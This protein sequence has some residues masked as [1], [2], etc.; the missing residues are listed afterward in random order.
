MNG[1][2]VVVVE[3]VRTPIGRGHAEKG[4]LKDVHPNALLG[5][6]LTEVVARAGIDAAEVDDVIAGCVQQYGEQSLNIARNAWLQAGLPYETPATTIDRQCG[7]AQQAVNFGA[8]QIASGVHD[9]VIGCG[10]EHMGRIPLFVGRQL[11]ATVG[12]PLTPEL[13]E[14]YDLVDQGFSAELIAEQ[15]NLPRG[16]LDEI[17]ARSQQ[18]AE[19]AVEEGRFDREIQPVR[20]NGHVVSTDQG[21]RPGTIVVSCASK[22]YIAHSTSVFGWRTASRFRRNRS[23]NSGVP[24][25]IRSACRTRSAALASA[26]FSF[27]HTTSTCGL[28]SRSRRAADSTRG[29]PS[30]SVVIKS[31]RFKSLGLTLPACASTRRPTPAAAR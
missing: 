27:R 17:A 28:S 4:W 9:V 29:R 10:V 3:A 23:A 8:A 31:C 2:E 7:S 26:T 1:R 15:W 6:V 12:S 22:S 20:V 19:R 25:T 16:R 24:S 13:Y 18:R 5:S 30:Q 21:V 14:R 11:E